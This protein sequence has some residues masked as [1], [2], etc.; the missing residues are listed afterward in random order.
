ML[1]SSPLWENF[2]RP[3]LCNASPLLILWAKWIKVQHTLVTWKS[4]KCVENVQRSKTRATL[5]LRHVTSSVWTS[6]THPALGLV[7]CLWFLW[8]LKSEQRV[9]SVVWCDFLPGWALDQRV[10]LSVSVQLS[11]GRRA[12]D[13]AASA[14]KPVFK[15][16][17][18]GWLWSHVGYTEDSDTSEFICHL[19]IGASCPWQTIQSMKP[20]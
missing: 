1:G 4:W 13:S 7:A 12:D 2:H 10:S 20:R 6:M 18:A 14:L 8:M 16:A 9:V 5:M 17:T 11:S 3:V 19:T 15:P